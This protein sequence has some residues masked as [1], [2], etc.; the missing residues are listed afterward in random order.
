MRITR[1]ARGVF[2]FCRQM[3]AAIAPGGP[4]RLARSLLRSGFPKLL[5]GSCHAN[6]RV[7]RDAATYRRDYVR[8]HGASTRAQGRCADATFHAYGTR[9][10]AYARSDECAF[11]PPRQALNVRR[12]LGAAARQLTDPAVGLQLAMGM[13]ARGPRARTVVAGAARARVQMRSRLQLCLSCRHG[14]A[15]A[16]QCAVVRG[17]A[18]GNGRRRMNGGDHQR[19]DRE[20]QPI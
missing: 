14:V 3:Q 5:F 1:C 20:K 16:R 13:C 18:P 7:S 12:A 10:P 4:A 11:A 17:C 2:A 6:P 15:S 8:H 19:R 9:Q